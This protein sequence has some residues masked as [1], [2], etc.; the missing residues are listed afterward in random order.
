MT[1]QFGYDQYADCKGNQAPPFFISDKGR[2]IWS[3]KPLKIEFSG[4]KI[5][6]GSDGGEV[7]S[8]KPVKLLKDAFQYASKNFFP[9]SGKIPDPLLFTCP[10]YN[11]WIELQYNQNEKDILKYA[12][13]IFKNGFPAVLS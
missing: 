9:P 6:V 2:Y 11:T 3:D 12:E 1:R 7:V 13:N 4:D 8:G 10:Q 5:A